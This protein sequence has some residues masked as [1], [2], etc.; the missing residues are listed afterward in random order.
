MSL[1]D[2]AINK[3]MNECSH[4]SLYR[5]ITKKPTPK[6]DISQEQ[7]KAIPDSNM[8]N[9]PKKHLDESESPMEYRNNVINPGVVKIRNFLLGVT[10]E[11]Q[12]P[13]ALTSLKRLEQESY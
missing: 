7:L 13:N 9:Q 11:K 6:G 8:G 4:N 2:K 10:S 1:M 12:T 5:T 3:A